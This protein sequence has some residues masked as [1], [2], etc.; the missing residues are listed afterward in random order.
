MGKFV[1]EKTGAAFLLGG[2]VVGTIVHGIW[3]VINKS[4]TDDCYKACQDHVNAFAELYMKYVGSPRT[5]ETATET[6]EKPEVE[7]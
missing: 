7:A 6:V 3:C 5:E 1:N 2:A 4:L